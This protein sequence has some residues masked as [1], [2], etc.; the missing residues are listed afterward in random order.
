MWALAEESRFEQGKEQ[1]RFRHESCSGH[2]C[3]A[4]PLRSK[5]KNERRRAHFSPEGMLSTTIRQ[6]AT[7]VRPWK[8]LHTWPMP[9]GLPISTPKMTCCQEEPCALKNVFVQVQSSR[10]PFKQARLVCVRSVYRMPRH[11]RDTHGRAPPQHG[12]TVTPSLHSDTV[13]AQ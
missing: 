2:I 1:R 8:P 11:N 3:S 12:L 6:K 10:S 13:I 5:V 9:A 7:D 4:T